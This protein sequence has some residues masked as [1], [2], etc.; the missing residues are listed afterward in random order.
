MI[1]CEPSCACAGSWGGCR[2]WCSPWPCSRRA[3]TPCGPASASSCRCC[4]QSVARRTHTG[5]ASHLQHTHT[6]HHY[7][8]SF[9]VKVHRSFWNALP[10]VMQ[11]KPSTDGTRTYGTYQRGLEISVIVGFTCHHTGSAHFNLLHIWLQQAT[12]AL[13]PHTNDTNPWEGREQTNV[14]LFWS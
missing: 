3:W 13:L 2:T 1:W 11:L 12:A 6:R 10:S 4:W 5:M 7:S 8:R 9:G 14:W